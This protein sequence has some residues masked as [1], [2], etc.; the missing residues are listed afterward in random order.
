MARLPALFLDG[1]FRLPYF[2]LCI[3]CV[4]IVMSESSL[5]RA[6]K[7]IGLFVD[8]DSPPPLHWRRVRRSQ[9]GVEGETHV[10]RIP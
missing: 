6:V 10:E 4:W 1:S 7:A 5:A 9:K 8:S 2:G 3:S